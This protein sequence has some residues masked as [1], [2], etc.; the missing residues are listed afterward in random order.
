MPNNMTRFKKERRN[1]VKL[2]T[3]EISKSWQ[4]WREILQVFS[5]KSVLKHKL[6]VQINY[7]NYGD[8]SNFTQNDVK[9]SQQ[10]IQNKNS[11][12]L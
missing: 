5:L 3:N 4:R 10:K 1:V 9:V 11:Q 12:K 2:F 7:Y 6:T 8:I